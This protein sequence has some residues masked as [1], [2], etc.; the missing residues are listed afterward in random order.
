MKTFA[1]EEFERNRNVEDATKIRYLVSTGKE[2]LQTMRRYVDE[3]GG[4]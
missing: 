2:Q 4:R 3:M 1:K